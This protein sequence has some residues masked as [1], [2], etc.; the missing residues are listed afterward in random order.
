MKDLSLEDDDRY[1]QHRVIFLLNIN[2]LK[3]HNI[4]DTLIVDLYPK[5]PHINCT[6]VDCAACHAYLAQFLKI[7]MRSACSK[8]SMRK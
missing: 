1:C 7:A 4:L 3:E 8:P 5:D 2:S 6:I